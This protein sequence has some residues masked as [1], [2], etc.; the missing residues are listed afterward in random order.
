MDSFIMLFSDPF[1]EI[2]G[3]EIIPLRTLLF[4]SILWLFKLIIL[5]SLLGLLGSSKLNFHFIFNICLGHIF[6]GVYL[7]TLSL[8]SSY[9]FYLYYFWPLFLFIISLIVIHYTL[10]YTRW[11]NDVM[12]SY[13]IT[14]SIIRLFVCFIIFWKFEYTF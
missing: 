14:V 11:N 8:F 5:S 10:L 7:V 6:L 3:R 1:M 4:Q 13:C 2:R 12:W 9:H